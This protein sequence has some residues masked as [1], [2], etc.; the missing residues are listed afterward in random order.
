MSRASCS[1]RTAS[2]ICA[3]L[4]S[5]RSTTVGDSKPAARPGVG[6][7]VRWPPTGGAVVRLRRSAPGIGGGR[8]GGIDRPRGRGGSGARAGGAAACAP[9]WGSLAPDFVSSFGDPNTFRSPPGARGVNRRCSVLQRH[10]ESLTLPLDQGEGPVVG[11]G[12]ALLGLI[13]ELDDRG[14]RVLEVLIAR[15]LVDLCETPH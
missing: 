8:G 2:V 5:A 1:A 6:L 15:A 10:A 11:L 7:G 14:G 13:R 3:S 12:L 4:P 9:G